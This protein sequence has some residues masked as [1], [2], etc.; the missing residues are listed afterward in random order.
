MSNPEF[1]GLGPEETSLPDW[2]LL[3][4]EAKERLQPHNSRIRQSWSCPR[5]L[6]KWNRYCGRRNTKRFRIRP[7]LLTQRHSSRFRATTSQRIQ[8]PQ[9]NAEQTATMDSTGRDTHAAI[10]YYATGALLV[11]CYEVS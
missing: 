10:V 11:G 3:F 8:H 5:S 7:I 6:R 2:H 9:R 1:S 4:L